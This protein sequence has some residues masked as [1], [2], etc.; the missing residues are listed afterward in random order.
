MN[1]KK[2]NKLSTYSWIEIFD[3][4]TTK[5][6]VNTN[7]KI[8]NVFFTRDPIVIFPLTKHKNMVT[9]IKHSLIKKSAFTAVEY[10]LLQLN[11]NKKAKK[12]SKICEIFILFFSIIDI[13]TKLQYNS[14]IKVFN[15]RIKK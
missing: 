11:I 13:S 14:F 7:S 6:N 5:Y 10:T 12:Y 15:L 2:T 3:I 4:L 8:C 1:G 9:T